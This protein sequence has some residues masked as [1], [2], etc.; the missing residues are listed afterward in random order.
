MRVQAKQRRRLQFLFFSPAQ[1]S[2]AG[3]RITGND[4]LDPRQADFTNP[5]DRDVV[6]PVLYRICQEYQAYDDSGSKV[7]DQTIDVKAR[8]AWMR[9]ILGIEAAAAS[10]GYHGIK[11]QPAPA[12]LEARPAQ[13]T[14]T[15]G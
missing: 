4:L 13:E 8:P 5:A 9:E 6:E 12:D 7:W 14:R 2:G 10:S 11:V 3:P 15:M 1:A